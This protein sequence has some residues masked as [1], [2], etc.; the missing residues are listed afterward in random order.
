MFHAKLLDDTV[1]LC[2]STSDVHLSARGGGLGKRSYSF[3]VG[4]GN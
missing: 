2:A 3:N 1:K 4:L